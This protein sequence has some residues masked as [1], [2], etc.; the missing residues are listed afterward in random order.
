MP[1]V[2]VKF[3]EAKNLTAKD[4]SGTSDPYCAVKLYNT[5]EKGNKKYEREEKTKVI[6]KTLNPTW[7]QEQVWTVHDPEHDSLF[8]EVRDKDMMSSTYIGHVY[9]ALYENNLYL[10]E[11]NDKW[12]ELSGTPAGKIHLSIRPMGFGI[13]RKKEEEKQKASQP[14]QQQQQPQMGYGQQQMGY[15]Q[16]QMMGYGQPQMGYGQPQMMGYGQPQMMPQMMPQMGF[17]NPSQP[18]PQQQSFPPQQQQFYGQGN[19]PYPPPQNQ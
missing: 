18:Y 2:I 9:V 11:E 15:Q 7:N 12:F 6:K 13:D 3:I 5:A 10:D 1:S 17:M 14:Q 8:I 4:L 19:P 16:P